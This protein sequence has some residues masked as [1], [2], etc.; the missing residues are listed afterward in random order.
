MSRVKRGVFLAIWATALLS[1]ALLAWNAVRAQREF[2]RLLAAG[3][4]ALAAGDT[5]SAIDAFSGAVALKDDSMVG[6]LKRGDSYRRRGELAASL[7]DLRE[8]ARLDTTAPQPAE[9]LGDVNMAMARHDR[10][11]DEYRRF[12]TLDDREPR[13][14][15]KL[16]L[17]LYQSGDAPGAIDPV[18]HALALDD[19]LAQAHYLLGVCLAS[20]GQRPAAVRSLLR[21]LEINPALAPAREALAEVYGALG[22]SRDR[23]DQLELL[24]ALEPG[25]VERVTS[26][27]LAY[28]DAGRRDAALTTLTRAADRYPGSA[29]VLLARTH[30]WLDAAQN[31]GDGASLKKALSALQPIATLDSAS[32]ETLTLYGRALLLSGEADT[33][34]LV[35]QQAV[36]RPPID[37]H[38]FDALIEAADRLGH[39]AVSRD[40]MRRRAAL[41]T[42]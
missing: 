33:A 6:Y 16:A 32:S 25:R 13:V 19:R 2:R 4:Q 12:V 1:G 36:A 28:A 18:R 41:G 29:Q 11:A 10:A 40:A 42:P 30:V 15:Y 34:E 20:T 37:P 3:D 8:A 17:A 21:A 38:A 24:A 22:R 31:D 26:V 39:D 27:A 14:Y 35:L 7:R 23:I 9:L 5:L